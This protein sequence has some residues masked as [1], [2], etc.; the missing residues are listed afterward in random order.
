MFSVFLSNGTY[1]IYGKPQSKNLTTGKFFFTPSNP[2]IGLWGNTAPINTATVGAVYAL[3]VI[4][5]NKTSCV[6]P[7]P[8]PTPP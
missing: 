8:T 2:L 5:L 3:G 7:A 1:D 4:T 6:A